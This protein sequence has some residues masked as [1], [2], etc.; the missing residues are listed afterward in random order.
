MYRQGPLWF[1]VWIRFRLNLAG[2][3]CS[4]RELSSDEWL[5][6]LENSSKAEIP[7]LS[8][9]SLS[10]SLELEMHAPVII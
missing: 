7:K 9:D 10:Q 8:F 3:P 4:V 6:E 2:L 5:E 1:H